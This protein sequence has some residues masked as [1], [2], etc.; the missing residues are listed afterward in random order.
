VSIET[1][2]VTFPS[3]DAAACGLLLEQPARTAA[4]AATPAR[5]RVLNFIVRVFLSM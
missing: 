2:M 3:G 4:S 1:V 5:Y